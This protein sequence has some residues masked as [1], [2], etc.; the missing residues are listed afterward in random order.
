MKRIATLALAALGTGLMAGAANADELRAY[1]QIQ[2]DRAS[3]GDVARIRFTVPFGQSA[4]R[5][6]QTRLSFGFA[7]N[8]GDGQTGSVDVLSLSLSGDTPRLESPLAFNA[9]GDGG[10]WYGS[11]RNWLWIGLGAVAIWGIYE[12]T[13]DDEDSGPPP[14]S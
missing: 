11:P 1:D 14:P 7:R 10:P 4:S 9:N 5:P 3:E 12:A 6:E 13:D 8:L 2:S